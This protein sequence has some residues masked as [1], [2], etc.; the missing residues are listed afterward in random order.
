MYLWGVTKSTSG[1]WYNLN[2]AKDEPYVPGRAKLKQGWDFSN[3]SPGDALSFLDIILR[4]ADKHG[5]S[6]YLVGKVA[7]TIWTDNRHL[8]HALT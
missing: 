6:M 8:P 7:V 4:E 5:S 3:R 1:F 2:L